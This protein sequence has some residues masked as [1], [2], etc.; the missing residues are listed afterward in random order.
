MI[1]CSLGRLPITLTSHGV[2]KKR[3]LLNNSD[4]QTHITQIAITTLNCGEVAD[5]HAHKTMEEYFIVRKG[6]AEITVDNEVFVCE[7]DDFIQ[8]PPY[9]THQLKAVTDLEILTIGCATE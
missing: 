9:S 7:P 5:L 6:I 2:G 1:K 4:T 8:I 3:V